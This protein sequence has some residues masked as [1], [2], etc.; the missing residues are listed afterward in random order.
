MT[1]NDVEGRRWMDNQAKLDT[2][3]YEYRKY[4][5]IGW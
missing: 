4:A 5:D 1:I 3:C 2:P